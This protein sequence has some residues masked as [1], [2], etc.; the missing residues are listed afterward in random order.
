MLKVVEILS[1]SK[2]SWEDATKNAVERAGKTVRGI[3]GVYVNEQSAV[4]E[5]DK[6]VAYRVNLKITFAVEG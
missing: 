4:V 5:N 2:K 1:E 6:V 3:K